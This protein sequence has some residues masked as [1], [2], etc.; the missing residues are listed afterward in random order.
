MNN[1]YSENEMD[2]YVN[3]VITPGKIV[4]KLFKKYVINGEELVKYVEHYNLS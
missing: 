2:Y 3:E 1:I 4:D